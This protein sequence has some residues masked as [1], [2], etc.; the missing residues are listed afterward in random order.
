MIMVKKVALKLVRE[1]GGK[2][3]LPDKIHNPDNIYELFSFLRDDPQ[4]NFYVLC[5]D[6]KNSIAGFCQIAKGSWD[7][8]AMRVADIIKPAILMNSN[9]I[10]VVHNH[11]TGDPTPSEDDK[12]T[13]KKIAEACEIFSLE[14]LDHIIIGEDKYFSFMA[15]GLLKTTSQ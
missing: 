2:Y 11:P 13:T 10:I 8:C 7:F 5:L 15:E 14:L 12:K 3:F 9:S 1:R 6:T 4:E